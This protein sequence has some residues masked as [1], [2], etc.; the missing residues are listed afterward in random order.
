MVVVLPTFIVAD[1]FTNVTDGFFT[2]TL[3]VTFFPLLVFAVIV[4]F[5]AFFPF[6]TPLFVTVATF[7][8]E[9]FQVIFSVA[10]TGFLVT[11]SV[12]FLP[13]CSV[14]F[15][16]LIASFFVTTFAFCTFT[17]QVA[18]AP[19]FMVTVTFAVPTFLPVTLPLLFTVAIF[20]LEDFQPFTLS[21]DGYLLLT[22]NADVLLPA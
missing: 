20:V 5:P 10:E 15:L 3:Q 11:V 14:S 19:L 6:T 7:V 4:A 1:F 8:L 2:V 13:F 18:V 16:L 9:D 22:F 12:A 17:V 21:F